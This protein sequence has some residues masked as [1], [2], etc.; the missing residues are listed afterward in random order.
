[1]PGICFS[2]ASISTISASGDLA[3]DASWA[4]RFT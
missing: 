1:M 2:A 4:L 3:A